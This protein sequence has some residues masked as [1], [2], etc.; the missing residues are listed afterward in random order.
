[1]ASIRME[2]TY[3]RELE[4][5][6]KE[7]WPVL[8]PI[9]TMEYHSSICPYGCDTLASI[10]LI[11]RIAEKIDC[12]VM[13]PVWYGVASYAVGGPETNTIHVDCDTFE[14]YIYMILK[15]LMMSGFNRNI[16]LLLAHQCEDYNPM[17]LACMKA[18]RKLIFEYLD[19]T[20]GYGWW[21]KNENKDFY[22]NMSAED[23][24]WKWIRV[25]NGTLGLTGGK[26][27]QSAK[28]HH[29]HGDHAGVCE[30]SYLEYMYP[31]SI[32]LDRFND[33]DDWF[34]ETA[35]QMNA[36][37]I[38]KDLTEEMVDIFVRTINEQRGIK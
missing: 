34:K 25:L 36:D 6:K 35:L 3:P 22:D 7:R 37:P 14:Q 15:S 16:Y 32:K 23:N 20:K 17:G 9:G 21:G 10:G 19:K 8:I 33:S 13:P 29:I 28:K 38:G 27:L 5:A 12:V 30:C 1:M 11:D 26:G 31:G 2:M 18:A 4:K 24:P